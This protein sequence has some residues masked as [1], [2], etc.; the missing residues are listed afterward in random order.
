MAAV[1]ADAHTL[2][3]A[4]LGYEDAYLASA[5][6][7]LHSNDPSIELLTRALNGQAPA[8]TTEASLAAALARAHWYSGDIDAAQR[9]LRR[10]EDTLNPD[11]L[12]GRTRTAFARRIMAG[13]PGDADRLADACTVLIDAASASGRHDIAC[14]ALRQRVLALVELGDLADADDEIERLDRLIQLKGEVHYLAYAPLLRAMRMLQRGELPTA[15]R[16]NQRAAALGERIDSLHIA[17]LTLMQQFALN[18][19]TGSPGH[20]ATRLL[21]HAGPTGSNTIWYAAAA[22]DQA[23]NGQE[24]AARQLLE[25]GVG[26]TGVERVPFNE[27]WLFAVCLA[28][29]ASERAH[30]AERAAAIHTLLLPH[31]ELLVGNVAPVVGPV[32]HAAGLAALAAGRHADAIALLERA[33]QHA[34]RLL[35]RP[36]VVDALRAQARARQAAGHDHHECTERAEALARQLGMTTV[37]TGRPVQGIGNHLTAREREILTLITLGHSNQEI[38]ERLYISYRTAKT[39]V[40]HILTKLGARDRADAAIIARKAGLDK[41]TAAT[42]TSRAEPL[43]GS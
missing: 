42:P 37:S 40:S 43:P 15:K 19:W 33:A 8:S 41:P 34:E 6:I 10:A 38:A 18:R 25:R 13:T 1:D 39:H 5:T 4:A 22:I 32:S 17:Q 16:L 20:Y 31:I 9:W 35:C 11:D 28:A 36:W 14:D 29:V 3:D 12:P 24:T 23:D 27:F 30:D 2:V 21:R 7:R 26:A